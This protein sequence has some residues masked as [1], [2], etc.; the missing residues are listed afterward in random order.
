MYIN[1]F[2]K[3]K[4]ETDGEPQ[5]VIQLAKAI[6]V[7]R[8]TVYN[9]INGVYKPH[10]IHVLR[11]VD[12]SEGAITDLSKDSNKKTTELFSSALDVINAKAQLPS[13]EQ[14]HA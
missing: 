4:Q 3:Q 7:T 5:S 2:L 8:Q 10:W 9:W 6:G 13:K 14:P 11:L 1:D 12:L